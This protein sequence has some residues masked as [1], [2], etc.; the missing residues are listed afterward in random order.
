MTGSTTTYPDQ[1]RAKPEFLVGELG[2]HA[3][4]FL[5]DRVFRS[6][7][8]G[9]K[10][11][12]PGTLKLQ[13][14]LDNT[15]KLERVWGDQSELFEGLGTGWPNVECE[16]LTEDLFRR[17]LAGIQGAETGQL[18]WVSGNP[19][20][21]V[22][23]PVAFALSTEASISIRSGGYIWSQ[24]FENGV[25]Q[26]RVDRSITD[27]K[28]TRL[29][30][31][32]KL[33]PK[34]LEDELQV[35]PFR[36][37]LRE[38]ASLVPGL[39]IEL[40]YKSFKPKEFLSAEGMTDLL[41]FFVPEED[42]LHEDPFEF[43]FDKDGLVYHCS[44][45]LLHS[46]MERFKAFADFDESYHGGLHEQLF[47]KT[48]RQMVR[49]FCKVEIPVKRQSLENIASSRMSYFG[50]FGSTIPYQS[51][52]R[53]S[54]FVRTLPGVAAA[55]RVGSPDLDWETNFR[56]RVTAPRFE[57]EVGEALSFAFRN[58]L[59]DHLETIEEW[60]KQWIPKKRRKRKRKKKKKTQEP[61]KPEKIDEVLK[62]DNEG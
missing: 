20:L 29:A 43:R 2:R 41:C 47:R 9:A 24:S 44:A 3:V 18:E 15:L 58:W 30:L 46:A 1:I 42:R 45:F 62:E 32:L 36:I 11:S 6:L 40:K 17:C 53:K 60:R 25:A 34:L 10:K 14:E 23:L 51:E 33:D 19:F 39:R 35:Y 12:D 21:T 38:F 27:E 28:D 37:R 48:V 54:Q 13:V 57:G 49:R 8:W 55:I 4:S 50:Q 16:S 52:E 22:Y 59:L 5:I 31:E 56:A 26:R 61:A 7:V